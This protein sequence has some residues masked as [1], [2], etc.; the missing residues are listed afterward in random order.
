MFPYIGPIPGIDTQP[1]AALIAACI[2]LYALQLKDPVLQSAVFAT[3]IVALHTI[4]FADETTITYVIRSFFPI[5]TALFIYICCRRNW[6]IIN[7]TNIMLVSAIYIAVGLVQKLFEPSFLTDLVSRP[8]EHIALL[9][10]SGRGVRSLAPEPAQLGHMLT[11]LNMIIFL[12]YAS[13][14]AKITFNSFA[15]ISLILFSAN[16]YI[17]SSLYSFAVHCILISIVFFLYRPT[18][19][20]F[21]LIALTFYGAFE[22]IG[23]ITGQDSR[24]FLLLNDAR[25]NPESLFRYG[26]IYRVFNI[27]ISIISSIQYG[28]FGFGPS[29]EKVTVYL[30]VF[31]SEFSFLTG[32]RNLGGLVEFFLQFGILS[33]AHYILV[34]LIFIGSLK[35]ITRAL[36]KYDRIRLSIVYILSLIFLGFQYGSTSNPLLWLLL[37]VGWCAPTL[38]P[39]QGVLPYRQASRP[40]ITP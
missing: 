15:L 31:G 37:A 30:N 8:T 27:P 23:T 20:I 25:S 3:I 24:L 13:K 40:G 29:D 5:F 16:I 9:I 32:G 35:R 39:R 14:R 34:F 6:I 26:A 33:A 10:Q 22:L 38:F 18:V 17:S 36:N 4:F 19:L 1:F 7:T 11:I 21:G 12:L 2:G 28:I